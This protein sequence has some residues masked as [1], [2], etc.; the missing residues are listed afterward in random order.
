MVLFVSYQ[1]KCVHTSSKITTDLN[2]ARISW[3][4]EK[5]AQLEKVNFSKHI[6]MK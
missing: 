5:M 3:V 1:E 6:G 4:C 2:F